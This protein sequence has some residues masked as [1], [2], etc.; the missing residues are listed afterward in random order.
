MEFDN[1]LFGQLF[2]LIDY[3]KYLSKSSAL[4][5]KLGSVMK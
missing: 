2:S 1:E 5:S 3:D 4:N